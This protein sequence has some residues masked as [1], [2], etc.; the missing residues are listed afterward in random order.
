MGEADVTVQV[1]GRHDAAWEREM[2]TVGLVFL[3]SGPS[4]RESSWPRSRAYEH[5]KREL[6]GLDVQLAQSG[7]SGPTRTSRMRML[8]ILRDVLANDSVYPS[9]SDDGEG[10]LVAEWRAGRRR[11]DIYVSDSGDF[12]FR[13]RNKGGATIYN[14]TST[15]HLRRHLR[16]L[17]AIVNAINP[18]WRRF[19]LTG[20]VV[21]RTGVR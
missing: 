11:I 13:V 20:G 9:I 3:T 21:S 17:T 16:D 10:G 14:G 18:G 4:A 7:Q 8:Q 6:A 12:L 1:I 2:P 19:F 5:A 15:L